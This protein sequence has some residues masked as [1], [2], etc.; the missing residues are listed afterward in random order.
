M[1]SLTDD[2]VVFQYTDTSSSESEVPTSL[3]LL[4]KL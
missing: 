2:G 1:P 3:L 4:C